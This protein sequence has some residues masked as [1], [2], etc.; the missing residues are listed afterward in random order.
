MVTMT[1]KAT[2]K[3]ATCKEERKSLLQTSGL[4]K[5]PL[6]VPLPAAAARGTT[7][8]CSILCEGMFASENRQ[9]FADLTDNPKLPSLLSPGGQAGTAD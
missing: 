9:G 4:P 7:G 3:L 5:A 8:H 2:K 6:G 1:T